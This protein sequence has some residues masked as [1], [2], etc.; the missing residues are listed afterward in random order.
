MIEDAQRMHELLADPAL[1]WEGVDARVFDGE[2][3]RDG[4]DDG[5]ARMVILR[6]RVDLQVGCPAS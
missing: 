6:P 1:V 3:A 5:L 4:L 2:V